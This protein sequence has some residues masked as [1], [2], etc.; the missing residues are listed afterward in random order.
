[1]TGMRIT[2]RRGRCGDELDGGGL[3]T[4]DGPARHG[5]LCVCG[6]ARLLYEACP[7]CLQPWMHFEPLE[8]SR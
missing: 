5:L 7:T 4:W 1:M 2:P 8:T 3:H 6:K